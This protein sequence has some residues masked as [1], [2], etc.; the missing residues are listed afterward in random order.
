M[1]FDKVISLFFAYYTAGCNSIHSGRHFDR[2]IS[3]KFV[4]GGKANT[5]NM[6]KICCPDPDSTITII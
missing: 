1:K 6:N 5:N 3:F 4:S 2:S